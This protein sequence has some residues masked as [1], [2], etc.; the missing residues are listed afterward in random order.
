M[1]K[2]EKI[3]FWLLL[4]IFVF[5]VIAEVIKNCL[6]F[7]EIYADSFSGI[8]TSVVGV[9]AT[10]SVVIFTMVIMLSSFLNK[11]RYGIPVIRYFIKYRN[12]VLNHS[13]IFYF[14]M[15]LLVVSSISLFFG[16]INI[17]FNVGT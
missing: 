17:F 12:K 7:I 14:V 6:C 13:N 2:E 10:V 11:E 16:W 15:I 4:G 1:R 8:C 9:Q 5:G 3:I